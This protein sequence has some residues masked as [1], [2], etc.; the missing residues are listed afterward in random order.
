MGEEK[1]KYVLH[2]CH[3]KSSSAPP[4]PTPLTAPHLPLK[5][6]NWPFPEPFMLFYKSGLYRYCSFCPNAH[7]LLCSEGPS[8]FNWP[9][10]SFSYNNP[11]TLNKVSIHIIFFHSI[12]S[13]VHLLVDNLS[14]SSRL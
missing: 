7:S 1:D 12:S 10:S 3:R 13:T 9:E 4:L 5:Q 2:I 8:F 14:S 6:N 11:P